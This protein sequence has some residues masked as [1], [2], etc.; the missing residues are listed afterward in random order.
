M[1]HKALEQY[2]SKP[3]PSLLFAARITSRGR[4]SQAVPAGELD[5]LEKMMIGAA[6]NRNDELTNK[7]DTK[8]LR[9]LRVPGFLGSL[10]V[11]HATAKS[12]QA[13]KRCLT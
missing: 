3:M 1:Y 12:I 5:W 11:G 10:G 4:F 2:D 13:L 8:L 9:E 6:M 7:K